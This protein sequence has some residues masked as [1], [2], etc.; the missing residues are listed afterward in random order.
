M[1][2]VGNGSILTEDEKKELSGYEFPFENLVFEAGGAK[3]IAYIGALQ[4]L[5]EVGAMKKV[6]RFAGASAGSITAGLLAVGYTATALQRLIHEDVPVHDG[7][8]TK[9]L[10]YLFRKYGWYPG[11]DFNKWYSK[12]LEEKTG[13]ADITFHQVYTK[14]EKELCIAVTNVN[15]MDVCYCHVKTT[16]DMPI[17]EAVRMS[18]SIPGIFCAVKHQLHSNCSRSPDLFVDGAMLC[19]FPIHCYDGWY[20]SMKPEDSFLQRF[21][22]VSL[23]DVASAWDR[24]KR[25][26][27]KN[28]KTPGFLLYSM[29]DPDVFQLDLQERQMHHCKEPPQDIPDTCLARKFKD[30]RKQIEEARRKHKEL[31]TAMQQFLK[32]LAQN[33]I[34]SNGMITRDEFKKA[35]TEENSD[36]TVFDSIDADNNQQITFREL[37]AFAEKQGVLLQEMFCGHRRKKISN[38]KEHFSAIGRGLLLATK[39]VFIS[40]DDVH[41]TAGIDT[42]YLETTSFEMHKEDKLF[43]VKQGKIGTIA[44]IRNYIASNKLSKYTT[45][46]KQQQNH[47]NGKQNVNNSVSPEPEADDKVTAEQTTLN[48]QVKQT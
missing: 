26:G 13:N 48:N 31:S 25:F 12:L 38:L 24:K 41:R 11:K 6:R 44:Y 20:L 15:T 35:M 37:M 43:L 19:S 5:E 46:M 3:G 47:E 9:R 21:A 23:K 30:D 39:H 29:Y 27:E 42:V 28:N 7:S 34:D 1:A 45:E 36:F 33:D 8:W 16:P 4:V 40:D 17:R 10:Y 32:V 18:M 2:T 22:S 14:Y